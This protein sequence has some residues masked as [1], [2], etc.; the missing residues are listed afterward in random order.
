MKKRMGLIVLATAALA[1]AAFA[2]SAKAL[3]TNLHV[4][5]G[6]TTITVTGTSNCDTYDPEN[7][8]GYVEVYKPL[9]A[10]NYHWEIGWFESGGPHNFSFTFGAGSGDTD[11]SDEPLRAGDQYRVYVY[12]PCDGTQF[13]QI[14]VPSN[15]P[16]AP[17]G[18]DRYIYCAAAGNTDANGNPLGVGQTLNLKYGE[19]DQDKRYAGATLGFWVQGAGLTCQLTPAQAALASASTVKVNHTGAANTQEGAQVYTLVPA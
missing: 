4:S 8:W 14:F 1:V 13:S 18:P 10:S 6:A 9:G 7:H 2:G 16:P 17:Q 19:P 12:D 5:V 3:V 11:G 15:N